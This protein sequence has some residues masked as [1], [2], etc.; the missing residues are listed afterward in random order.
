MF[1]IS[2]LLFGDSFEFTEIARPRKIRH[3]LGQ[4]NL[5]KTTALYKEKW[6]IYATRVSFV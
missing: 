1:L 3:L 2:Y 5:D 6:V 4:V